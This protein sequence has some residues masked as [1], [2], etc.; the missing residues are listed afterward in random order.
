MLIAEY[1]VGRLVETRGS[2]P[3]T[4]E[5]FSVFRSS[6]QQKM[7]LAGGRVIALGDLR[8]MDELAPDVAPMVLG[9]LRA[10]NVRI[11][12]A[13]HLVTADSPFARQY[14]RI[15]GA[16]GNPLRRMFTSAPAVLTW[17]APVLTPEEVARL[18]KILG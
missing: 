5:E 3:L 14:D 11:E 1:Q 15:I 18:K 12:R 7:V 6:F 8:A 4:S 10:D 17:L 16:T 9:M 13:A 2:G